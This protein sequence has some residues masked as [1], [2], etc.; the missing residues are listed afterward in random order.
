MIEIEAIMQD[1]AESYWLK[2]A[3]QSALKRDP[4]DALRDAMKLIS[5][6]EKNLVD[7]LESEACQ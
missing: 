7:V 1:N 2:S 3:I 4:L 5:I 6:L